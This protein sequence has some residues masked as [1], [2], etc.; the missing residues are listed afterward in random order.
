MTL[1]FVP[2]SLT[3]PRTKSIMNRLSTYS[4]EPNGSGIPTRR[5]KR[6][7]EKHGDKEELYDQALTHFGNN[8][9]EKAVTMF[10]ALL[11]QYPD[12]VDGHIGLDTHTNG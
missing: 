6:K 4:H 12:Y 2:L 8:E 9:L 11:E 1:V 7:R 10:N 3:F 5:G